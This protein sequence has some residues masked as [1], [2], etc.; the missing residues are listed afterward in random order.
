MGCFSGALASRCIENRIADNRTADTVLIVCG[1]WVRKIDPCK[2]EVYV[3]RGFRFRSPLCIMIWS[4]Q[5]S[6]CIYVRRVCLGYLFFLGCNVRRTANTKALC[7]I[8]IF[9]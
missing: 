8:T 2:N 5:L 3:V 9:D 1:G 4:K 6:K 7:A